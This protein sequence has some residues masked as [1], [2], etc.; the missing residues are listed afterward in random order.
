MRWRRCWNPGQWLPV[1]IPAIMAVM[2]FSEQTAISLE[3]RG[4]TIQ[5][6]EKIK[7]FQIRDWTAGACCT[8]LIILGIILR[9]R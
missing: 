3:L 6:N 8:A 5:E 4:G 1:A 9:G 7:P 2:R